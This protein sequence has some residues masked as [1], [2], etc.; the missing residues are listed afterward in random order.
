MRLKRILLSVAVAVAAAV[1]VIALGAATAQAQVGQSTTCPL[2]SAC[3]FYLVNLFNGHPSATTWYPVGTSVPDLSAEVFNGG[4][5][6]ANGFNLPVLGNIGDV[7]NKTLT[8][9][10]LLVLCSGTNYT[11][12]CRI[13]TADSTWPVNDTFLRT[14]HS[15][16]WAV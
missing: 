12:V 5:S 1:P 7:V 2:N 15:F 11:G 16:Y 6:G 9:G 8:G 10:P 13:L 3:L 14:V 4:G